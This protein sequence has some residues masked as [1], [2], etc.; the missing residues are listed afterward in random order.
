MQRASVLLVVVG[1]L[2]T[3][4][5]SLQAEEPSR[6]A[7]PTVPKAP[8]GQLRRRAM[9]GA[10]LA[11]VTK[12]VRDRHKLDGDGGVALEKVFQGTAAA[13]GDF[14]AGDVIL[15]VDGTKLTGVPMFL[16]KMAKTRAG[17]VLTLDVVRDGVKA[18]KRVALKEMLR[19]KGDGYDV[20]YGAV[21]SHGVR[22]RTIVTRPKAPGRHPAVMVLQGG[23]G[24]YP[25]D[26]PVGQPGAFTWM[27]RDLTRHGYVT[28]R[29]ER[30]GCGDSEGG[31]LRDVDFDTELDGYKQALRALKQFDFVDGDHVFLFGQSMGGI[32]APLIAVDVPVRGIA[33]YGTGCTT[34]FES[35][36]GQRRRSASLDGTNLAEVD[37]EVLRQ[38]RFW[39]PLVV[40]KKTPRE[41]LEKDPELRKLEWVTDEKYVANR[42]YA[43]HH[44]LA[45]KNLTEAWAKVAATRLS[46]NRNI[47]SPRVVAIWGTSDIPVDRAS[48]A[49][50][51]EVVN[52]A[53]P[54]NGTFIALDSLDHFFYHAATPK[55]SYQLS[56]PPGKG[57]PAREFSPVILETLR[58]WLDETVGRARKGS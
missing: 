56:K 36:V 3:S 35:V 6:S 26:T 49:W 1:G 18:K 41:I 51:A 40:E 7:Q 19:E 22:L 50:I 29:V 8:E 2:L 23:I 48:S 58:A 28:L 45:D 39:Y 46:V 44:Q 38:A 13:D 25:I 54:G 53:K 57:A 43:F 12:E 9:F 31:S 4:A 24:C 34:W 21:T 32:I 11:P 20:V 42:H 33:V 30:P 15:G 47:A 52:R 14:K 27:V 37:R 10:Q 16:E 5:C 55:E 17:D